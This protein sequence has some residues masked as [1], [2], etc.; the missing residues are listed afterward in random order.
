MVPAAN[1]NGTGVVTLLA[2]AHALSA[3]PTSNVRVMLVST[4]SEESF[5][6][7]MHAFSKRYFPTL[8]VERTFIL[9]LDT[10]G[11][12]HLTAVRG[13]GMLKMY[14]YPAPALELVDSLAEELDI[15]LFPNVRLRN[16]SDGLYALKGGYP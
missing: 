8:P 13:E 10:V 1:D 11:S 16:A 4:G 5:M 12:P 7:G 9:A 2:L 14:D 6:E 3:N 15:R